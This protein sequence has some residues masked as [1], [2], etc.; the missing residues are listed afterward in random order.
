MVNV[1]RRD[2][3]LMMVMMVHV[4]LLLIMVMQ[5]VVMTMKDYNVCDGGDDYLDLTIGGIS[6]NERALPYRDVD[7]R[8][9]T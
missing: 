1:M 5:V 8:N 9:N 7:G 2:G 4:T 3:V 6:Q